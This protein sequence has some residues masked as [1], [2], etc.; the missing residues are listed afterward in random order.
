M[1]LVDFGSVT[2]RL[3]LTGAVAATLAVAHVPQAYAHCGIPSLHAALRE[4]RALEADPRFAS[5]AAQAQ[6]KAFEDQL[7]QIYRQA[8]PTARQVAQQ[9]SQVSSSAVLVQIANIRDRI[10]RVRAQ[11]RPVG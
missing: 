8:S 11:G 4:V 5:P 1:K 2:T 9:A 7:Q 10:Q 3:V 6:L